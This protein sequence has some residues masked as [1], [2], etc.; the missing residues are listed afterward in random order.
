MNIDFHFYLT[1]WAFIGVNLISPGPNVLNTITTAMGSGRTAGLYSALAVG[2]GISLWCLSMALG[3]SLVFAVFP[4]AQ[5]VM[6]LI[7]ATLLVWFA[8]KYLKAA[9]L[10]YRK[11]APSLHGVS[12]LTL[13][14]SFLRSLSVNALNPKALTTWLFVLSIFPI[15]KANSADV[16]VLCVGTSIVAM[17][18]HVVYAVVFST[19]TAATAYLRAAPLINASVGTFFLVVA[20][21]LVLTA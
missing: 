9:Y 17:T 19:S 14:A 15:A 18:V 21:K 16:L 4:I 2:L 5:T 8:S 1:V 11:R 6:R 10:G 13:R 20:V 7:G 12:G 3:V